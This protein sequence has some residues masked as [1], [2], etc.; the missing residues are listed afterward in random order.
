MKPNKKM[1]KSINEWK[2]KVK[3][4]KYKPYNKCYACNGSGF[5]DTKNS[6]SCGSCNGTG[7]EDEK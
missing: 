4:Q 5:Y 2:D 3:L 6:P 1:R 7:L